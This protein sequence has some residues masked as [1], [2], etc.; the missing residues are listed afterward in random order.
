MGRQIN[1]KRK[2]KRNQGTMRIMQREQREQ[3]EQSKQLMEYT[4]KIEQMLQYAQD[5]RLHCYRRMQLT[6]MSDEK[7]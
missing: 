7:R 4:G 1:K 3:T 6:D 5:Y 2:D